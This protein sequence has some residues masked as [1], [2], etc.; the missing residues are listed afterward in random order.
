L[1][2]LDA[3]LKSLPA[4]VEGNVMRGALRA[5]QTVMLNGARAELVAQGSVDS[6]E[7]LQSLRIRQAV[8]SKKFGWVRMRL[9]A[10]NPIAWYAHFVEY[11]TATFYTGSGK[12]R[13]RPY[14]IKAKDAEGKRFSSREKRRANRGGE[15][16]ALRF[17]GMMVEKVVHPGSK[18]KPFMR[19]AF[20]KHSKAAVNAIADY[21]RRRLP[22]EV[23]KAGR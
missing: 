8:R 13:R 15:A 5:G 12:S 1:K 20:D 23:A 9:I 14:V 3:I 16:S 19:R 21:I 10:G 2:E 17:M 6:G 11:G 22:K 18:P 4:K 7:L